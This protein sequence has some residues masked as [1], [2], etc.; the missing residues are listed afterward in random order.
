[1]LDSKVCET[2]D[3]K[4]G[5]CR[6]PRD[7][8]ALKSIAEKWKKKINLTDEEDR[9]RRSVVACDKRRTFCCEDPLNSEGLELLEKNDNICGVFAIY[10]YSRNTI[11]PGMQ[12][13]ITLLE[14]E[15]QPFGKQFKCGGSLITSEFVL[16]AAHCI[17]ETLV[18][19]RLGEHDHKF[20]GNSKI[21]PEGTPLD[22]PVEKVFTHPQFDERNYRNDIALIRLKEPVQ[23]TEWIRPT[24]L[25]RFAD[26]QMEIQEAESMEVIGWGFTKPNILEEIPKRAI[27]QR[28]GLAQCGID[29]DTKICVSGEGI[30]MDVGVSGGSLSHVAFYKDRQ[31]MVQAGIM[32]YKYGHQKTVYTD[33]A[34]FMG[35]IT[36]TIV[37][38]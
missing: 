36:E 28:L 20:L 17:S 33:V 12:P 26:L 22:V 23:Y 37:K 9:Y 19:V 6:R 4:L 16:T 31:R 32:S 11:G 15:T 3:K 29:D 21:F 38:N 1:M 25:P 24:C 8:P 35:W 10:V 2:H 34:E 27:V 18:S 14:Y 13:W 30:D 5:K 7:C